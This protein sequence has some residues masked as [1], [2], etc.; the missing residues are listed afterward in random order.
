MS[1]KYSEDT[2]Y[3]ECPNCANDHKGDVIV[4]CAHCGGVF[5]ELC[6]EHWP[7]DFSSDTNHCPHC[8]N[9]QTNLAYISVGRI[10]P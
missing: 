5:C 3:A 6:N 8:G 1:P 10:S 7:D 2:S 9:I 4:Q